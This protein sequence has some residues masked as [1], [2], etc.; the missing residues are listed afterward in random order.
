MTVISLCLPMMKSP[1]EE[2]PQHYLS[3]LDAVRGLAAAWVMLYHYFNLR[4]YEHASVKVLSLFINGETTMLLFVLSGFVL[5]YKYIVLK[6]SLDVR[7]FMLNRFFRLWPAFFLTILINYIYHY[8]A[9]I[10]IYNVFSYLFTNKGH[11]WEEA[12]LINYSPIT[13][14]NPTYY[15][16][17]WAVVMQLAIS[18]LMP[19]LIVLAHKNVKL[20]W[21][22]IVAILL[23]GN[24]M[25]ELF[26]YTIHYALGLL[27]SCYF[28]FINSD[29][30]K[31]HKWYKYRYWILAVSILLFSARQL[32]R[33]NRITIFSAEYK[34]W[35]HDYFGLSF[36]HYS[37]VASFVFL[38]FIMQSGKL[39]RVLNNAPFRFL[40]QISYCVYLTHWLF[41]K[42]IFDHWDVVLS[43]FS[44]EL[45]AVLVMLPIYITACLLLATM[46][47]YW[48]ELPGIRLSKHL[49]RKL[50]PSLQ[51]TA[52]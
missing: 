26:G 23:I 49:L 25:G 28:A 1:A 18:F 2:K 42:M 41:A 21:W 11:F 27:V 43:Y 10:D 12:L 17:G 20:I 5:S 44:S 36:S 46:M 48:V 7:K 13:G 14:V 35:A 29:A 45:T 34:Y 40:G 30:I 4:F 19:F 3:Y 6:H 39:K 8:R 16:P 52:E 47:H 37:A 24:T 9:E 32:D 33:F 15:M 22:L 50:K 38:I 51:I 31:Q